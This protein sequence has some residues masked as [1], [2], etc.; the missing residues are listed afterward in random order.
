[1]SG[2]TRLGPALVALTPVLA[3]ASPRT[4]QIDPEATGLVAITSPAGLLAGLSHP[5]LVVA[6]RVEGTVV[7]DADDVG[8]SR[9]EVRAPADALEVDD[10]AWRARHG[11]AK[12]VSDEDRRQ[13]LAN[14]RAPGQLD[15]AA[16]PDLSFVSQAVTAAGGR[17][18]VRG[19]LTLHGVTAEVTV[20]VEVEVHDGVLQGRGALR[21]SHAQFGLKPASVGLGTIRNAEAIELRLVIVAREAPVAPAAPPP[22]PSR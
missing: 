14:L 18:E 20:P 11:L 15:V 1:V 2:L 4:F 16:F 5:H 3:L 9:I 8:Q 13:I 7:H 12:P 10:P 21:I 6:R 22:G 17:L 19:R